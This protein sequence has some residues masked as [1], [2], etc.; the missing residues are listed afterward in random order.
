[1]APVFK[2]FETL[3]NTTEWIDLASIVSYH[4][5]GNG[6]TQIELQSGRRL[7]VIII[8]TE[9]AAAIAALP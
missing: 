4:P 8:D 5:V 3:E 7:V 1:M 2:Q 6:S 9:L